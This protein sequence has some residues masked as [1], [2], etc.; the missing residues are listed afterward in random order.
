MAGRTLR[1]GVVAAL[2]FALIWSIGLV[3]IAFVVPLYA[4]STTTSDGATIDTTGT[5]VEVNGLGVLGVVLA[6]LAGSVMTAL[7]I[8]LR[9]RYPIAGVLAWISA[10]G[11][12]LLALAGFRTIGTFILPV[13]LALIVAVA[14]SRSGAGQSLTRLPGGGRR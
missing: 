4:G 11:V 10:V 5:L 14:L 1:P 9:D 6:P 7:M 8:A 3:V 12:A 2:G 13:G